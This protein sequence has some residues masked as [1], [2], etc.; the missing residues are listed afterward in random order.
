M[1]GAQLTT[2]DFMAS[3]YIFTFI[4]NQHSKAPAEWLE[5]GQKIAGEHTKFTAYAAMMKTEL[6]GH[7][8]ARFGANF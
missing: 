7:L 5:T 2:A 8:A 3:S 4:W 6:E 1:C